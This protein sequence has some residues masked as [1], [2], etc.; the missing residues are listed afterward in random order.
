MRAESALY[1]LGSDPR[2][3][4]D[5]R[6]RE[7]EVAARLEALLEARFADFEA[8]TGDHDA[9]ELDPEERDRLRALGYL[10]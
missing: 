1:D 6:S 2:E 8:R 9:V 10:P 7:L 5:V 3:Q 4:R